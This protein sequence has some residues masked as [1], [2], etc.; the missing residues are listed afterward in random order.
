MKNVPGL[1]GSLT[2]LDKNEYQDKLC[3]IKNNQILMKS[4]Y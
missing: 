1:K 4:V 3:Q 2:G